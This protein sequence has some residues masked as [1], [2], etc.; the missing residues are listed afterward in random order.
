MTHID[1]SITVAQLLE[2]HPVA[3][4]VFIEQR[5]S[6]IGCSIAPFHTIAEACSEY[7]LSLDRFIEELAGII[8]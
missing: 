4:R 3:M 2:L 7:D 5:M 8:L 6:C 1:P